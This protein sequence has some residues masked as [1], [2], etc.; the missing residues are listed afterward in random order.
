MRMDNIVN[1]MEKSIPTASIIYGQ[2]ACKSIVKKETSKISEWKVH[3]WNSHFNAFTKIWLRNANQ[4][5]ISMQMLNKRRVSSVEEISKCAWPLS[6][7]RAIY[8]FVVCHIPFVWEIDNKLHFNLKR[9]REKQQG[10]VSELRDKNLVIYGFKVLQNVLEIN[11]FCSTTNFD[12]AL[13]SRVLCKVPD[14]GKHLSWLFN[15]R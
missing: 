1:L 11:G 8:L 6:T 5:F 3:N 12:N 13:S 2:V 14:I 7:Y 4:P 9:R 15:W 10:L